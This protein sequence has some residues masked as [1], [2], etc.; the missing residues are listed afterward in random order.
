MQIQK[1]FQQPNTAITPHQ[2]INK[3][4]SAQKQEIQCSRNIEE[5][6]QL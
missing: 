6:I 1:L 2:Q 5:N 4:N 3:Q